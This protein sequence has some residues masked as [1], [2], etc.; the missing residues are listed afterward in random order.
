M[1]TRILMVYPEVPVTYWSFKHAIEF[2][3]ARAVM[4]PLGL[5]TIAA[6]IPESY[7][8]TIVDCNVDPLTDED[9]QAADMV[10]ISAM[11]VQKESMAEVIRRCKAMKKTVVAGGPYATSSHEQIDGV[12]HFI[13]DEGELTLP[14]FLADYENGCA[15]H[16]YRA[17]GKPELDMSPIPRFDL[18]DHTKYTSIAVQNSRGCPFNCEFCDIIEMFGRKPRYKSPRQFYAE[19]EAVYATGFR[20]S[21]LSWT[22]ILSETSERRRNCSAR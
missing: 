10:M 18:I 20:E 9:I 7:N 12:D 13:L 5:L 17:D 1:S 3:S 2:T 19:L 21:I 6:M 11:I 22:I 4:P 8:I 15:R 14:A 16:L